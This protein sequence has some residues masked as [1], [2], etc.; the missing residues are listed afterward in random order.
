MKLVLF[1]LL[2]VFL[3]CVNVQGIEMNDNIP[4]I[5]DAQSSPSC[6]MC[7]YVSRF[8]KFYLRDG[9]NYSVDQV[10]S[11]LGVVCDVVS[12]QFRQQCSEFIE[13]NQA[14]LISFSSGKG[15]TPIDFCVNQLSSCEKEDEF[16]AASGFWSTQKN[17]KI[18]PSQKNNTGKGDYYD[19]G[20]S[21]MCQIVENTGMNDEF[22]VVQT[23]I[24]VSWIESRWEAGAVN[25]Y[26]G[27]AGLW[28]FLPQYW[29]GV[30]GV[31]PSSAAGFL[32]GQANANCMTYAVINDGFSPWSN[33]PDEC[34][35]C[36][37]K[38]N[39][40]GPLYDYPGCG[41]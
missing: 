38:S 34:M 35:Q 22:G 30:G 11:T 10:A 13:K 3:G 7:N 9:G 21:S 40:Y 20:C 32:N 16:T 8:L 36:V 41:C 37:W 31:C 17:A 27:A 2:G 33:E 18:N 15:A 29:G 19:Y 5:A 1:M 14:S 4:T 6:T 39:C 24:C 12:Q 26:S 23:M 28:Q 25:S